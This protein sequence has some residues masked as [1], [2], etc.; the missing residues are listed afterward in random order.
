M[1]RRRRTATSHIKGPESR[2]DF[3]RISISGYIFRPDEVYEL[4]DAYEK[5]KEAPKILLD[6]SKADWL[7]SIGV[8]AIAKVVA[9]SLESPGNQQVYVVVKEDFK[10]RYFDER[11]WADGRVFVKEEDI[12]TDS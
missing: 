3:Q 5:V 6:L 11:P 10:E 2:G 7:T 1:F 4:L 12:P 9:M 8:A